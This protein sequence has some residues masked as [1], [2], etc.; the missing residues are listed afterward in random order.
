[1]TLFSSPMISG[2][3]R[4][5]QFSLAH[6]YTLQATSLLPSR[7]L[8][9]HFCCTPHP[10]SALDSQNLRAR[11]CAL[12]SLAL[13]VKPDQVSLGRHPFSHLQGTHP[14]HRIGPG[15]GHGRNTCTSKYTYL[16]ISLPCFLLGQAIKKAQFMMGNKGNTQDPMSNW[17][18]SM[19]R[20]DPYVFSPEHGVSCPFP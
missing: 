14:L 20:D 9:A 19:D 5:P 11:S 13:L 1:M 12:F 15:V 16:Y 17:G 10:Y 4:Y 18:R 2:G 7:A 3:S 8:P 6:V